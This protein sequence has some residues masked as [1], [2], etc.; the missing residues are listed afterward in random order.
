LIDSCSI[1]TARDG[2]STLLSLFL[3][4]WAIQQESLS[5]ADSFERDPHKPSLIS[6]RLSLASTAE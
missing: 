5:L 2:I 4:K 1:Y 3:G 6:A